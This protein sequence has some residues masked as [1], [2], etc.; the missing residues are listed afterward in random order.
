M[1]KI[2]Q[3]EELLRKWN[4]FNYLKIKYHYMYLLS[5]KKYNFFW[6]IFFITLCIGTILII[7]WSK[8]IMPIPCEGPADCVRY[9]A[10]FECFKNN[11][12]NV[13]IEYPFNIR[14]LAPYLASLL[15]SNPI[16]GFH[17]LNGISIIL[18]ICS[19]FTISKTLKFS[20]M[21]FIIFVFWFIFH[22]LGVRLYYYIPSLVDPLCY[23]IYG[24]LTF[25]Y[26]NKQ[27]VIFL[28][29]L[30]ISFFAKESFIFI[31]I[32]TIVAESILMIYQYC[33]NKIIHY[34]SLLYIFGVLIIIF[35]YKVIQ[36]T[37]LMKIFPPA[38]NYE[39]NS[40][41]TILFFLIRVY[42]DPKLLVVWI[43]SFFMA[44]GCF[45]VL[46]FGKLNKL[47]EICKNRELMFLFF[48]TIGFIVLGLIA[49]SD[50]SRIIFHGIIFIICFLFYLNHYLNKS[51]LLLI[52]IVSIT[53][54]LNANIILSSYHI[55]YDYYIFKRL[56]RII[57]FIAINVF[58][59]LLLILIKK[60]LFNG[61]L[62]I[63][64]K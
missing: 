48:G 37:V 39:L 3:I 2:K 46:I 16:D 18:F 13:K 47:K 40:I 32:I 20:Y 56:D 52:W 12:F 49:G 35:I 15:S 55:E 33:K 26:I 53:S 5:S 54:V 34:D 61:K 19:F 14:P 62:K 25:F 51:Y 38:Q 7:Y 36:K 31:A 11:S 6:L 4:I 41:H 17:L 58:F 57:Y 8:T 29:V 28:I 43:G 59:M 30:F 45:N 50:M 60:Y 64:N 23:A 24:W 21:E 27:K 9:T 63:L 10:M 42:K 22:P 44:T 1:V